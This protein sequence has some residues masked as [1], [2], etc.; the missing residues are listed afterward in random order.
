[1]LVVTPDLL[2]EDVLLRMRTEHN[3]L[4]VVRDVKGRT[5]GVFTMEDVLEEMVGEIH[6]ETDTPRA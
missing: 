4:A 6:D 5:L 1:M 3:H 2:L